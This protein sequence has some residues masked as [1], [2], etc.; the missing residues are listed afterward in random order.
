MR[1]SSRAEA[2]AA[3]RRKHGPQ[4][5]TYFLRLER[6]GEP[7]G[8][9]GPRPAATELRRVQRAVRHGAVPE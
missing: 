5:L 4:A 2:E 9:A 8:A 3:Q 7:H 6:G 1:G